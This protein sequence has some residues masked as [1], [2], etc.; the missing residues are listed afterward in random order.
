MH[1]G[2]HG[3]VGQDIMKGVYYALVLTVRN[4][5][6][7]SSASQEQSNGECPVGM[8]YVYLTLPYSHWCIPMPLRFVGIVVV[9]YTYRRGVR[10]CSFRL[11]RP[12]SG[13]SNREASDSAGL[14]VFFMPEFNILKHSGYLKPDIQPA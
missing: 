2:T 11:A 7:I 14:H 8:L 9:L 13:A 1:T 5:E 12:F 10:R 3:W 4:P 6:K